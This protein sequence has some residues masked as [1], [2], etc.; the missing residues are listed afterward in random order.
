MTSENYS[1]CA[2]VGPFLRDPKFIRFDAILAC[3]GRTNRLDAVDIV[4]VVDT[5]EGPRIIEPH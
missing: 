5:V 4:W 1:F 2:I 3:D